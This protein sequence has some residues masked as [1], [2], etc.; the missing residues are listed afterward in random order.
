M[1]EVCF[2]DSVKGSLT[3]AQNCNNIIGGA[4]SVLTNSKGV[5]SYFEKRKALKRYRK[6]KQ[7]LQKQAVSLGGKREDIVGISFGLSEGDIKAPIS[8]EDC[9]RKDYIHST[10]SF[11]RYD[12]LEGI[13]QSINDFWSSCID[14]L[15]KLKSNPEKIRIWLDRTPDA[16]C[17]LLFV[18]DLLKN[19]ETEIHIVELPEKIQREDN[20]IVEYRGWGDVESELFGTFL[21]RERTL[22]KAEIIKL[23]QQ[24]EK[25]KKENSPLRVI[26][27]GVIISAD[28]SYYDSQIKCEF[29]KDTCKIA[30]IIG[31]ALAKQKI[32]TGGVFIAKRIKHFINAGELVVIDSSNDRFYGTV[33]SCA[34]EHSFK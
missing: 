31:N 3:L 1:L 17:G 8:F 13:E 29:P 22:T 26:E 25:L 27:K 12:E 7:E 4:V 21:D 14:D 9:P 24:W 30:N 33:V 20:C 28:E 16:Q 6:R 10:F 15:K 2:S 32:L 11:D 5:C 34:D 19:S 23:S 18:A